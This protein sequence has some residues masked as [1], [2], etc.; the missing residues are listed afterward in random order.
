MNFGRYKLSDLAKELVCIAKQSLEFMETDEEQYLE[1][2]EY[3]VNKGITPAD[4][5]IEKLK[6]SDKITVQDLKELK[7]FV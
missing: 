1:P 3:Y 2:L 4:V 7:L 5:I 6:N